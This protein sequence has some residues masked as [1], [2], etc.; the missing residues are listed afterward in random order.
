MSLL[1]QA[2]T[3]RSYIIQE[4]IKQKSLGITDP[5]VD[6]KDNDELIKIGESIMKE[7]IRSF[8]KVSLPKLPNEG[9]TAIQ[10][11]LLSEEVLANISKNLGTKDIVLCDEFPVESKTLA[12]TLKAIVGALSKSSGEDRAYIFVRDFVCTQLNQIDINELWNIE[13]P[14][15]Y[16]HDLCLDLK[17]DVP[18][19]RLLGECGKNTLLAA[20]HVGIY[21]NKELLGSG[22]GDNVENAID[23]A[24]RDSLRVLF[25]TKDH[26]K[27]FNFELSLDSLNNKAAM[28]KNLV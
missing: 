27:P 2:F 17:L 15:K 16:L 9:L 19:P 8:L 5:E 23:E 20:Y 7:Y 22:F 13:N 24:A 1:Q 10:N 21:C 28:K 12:S 3:H 11:H 14:Q 6:N 25:G 18:E 4:E 26:M